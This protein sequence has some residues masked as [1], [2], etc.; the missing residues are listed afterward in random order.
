MKKKGLKKAVKQSPQSEVMQFQA[1]NIDYHQ[2]LSSPYESAIIT[3][4]IG[5]KQFR[6]PKQYL[7]NH[8]QLLPKSYSTS[9]ILSDVHEDAGHTLVHYLCSGKYETISSPLD[10][11]KNSNAR[12]YRR[13]VLVYHASRKY[14][15]LNLESLAK[16]YIE[17]FGEGM[18]LHDILRLTRNVLSI[19]PEGETWLPNYIQGHLKRLLE[20]ADAN[21]RFEE[22]YRSLGHDHYFDNV[23]MKMVVEMLSDRLRLVSDTLEDGKRSD[24]ALRIKERLF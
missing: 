10:E 18:S 6:I 2:P 14:A 12:E 1:P 4:S 20:T 7:S 9:T 15:L 8:P 3:I 13:S 19:L 17:H 24:Q 16:H 5:Q 21:L 11:D 23:V 22:L